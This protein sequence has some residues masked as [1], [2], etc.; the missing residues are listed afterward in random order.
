MGKWVSLP[1]D[2]LRLQYKVI[3]FP[4]TLLGRLVV[5][6]FDTDAPYRLTYQQMLE[7]IDGTAG[8]I[9]G[10]RTLVRR[11][12]AEMGPASTELLSPTACGLPPVGFDPVGFDSESHAR[13]ESPGDGRLHANHMADWGPGPVGTTYL[14]NDVTPF[15]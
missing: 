1:W 3:R 12:R 15:R 5:R 8:T 14:V 11:A 7:S 9:L 10:D 13:T 6:T 4:L 2:V